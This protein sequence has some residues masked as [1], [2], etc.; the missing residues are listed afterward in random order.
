MT[1]SFQVTSGTYA[2]AAGVGEQTAI[3]FSPTVNNICKG[4][5]LD[6][7]NLTQSCTIRIQYQIDGTN[8]RT[9]QSVSWNTTMDD[10]VLIE[11]D[12]P[13][14]ASKSLRVTIQSTVTEGATRNIPFEYFTEG[15]GSGTVTFTYSVSN[16]ITSAP[17]PGVEVWVSTTS[18]GAAIIASGL[19]NS[20]GVV[21]FYLSS[22]VTYFF[23]RKHPNFSFS[24]PDTET[25]SS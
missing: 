11:G 1:I 2:H 3:T 17:I 5:W 13:V 8:Y 12:I 6:L 10:G 22:G 20:S 24:N 7:T 14:A 25:V 16:S 21:T 15:L 4:V 9:F 19:T 18:D 23:W